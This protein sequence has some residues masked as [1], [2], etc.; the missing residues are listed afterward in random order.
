MFRFDSKIW[1]VKSFITSPTKVQ[2]PDCRTKVFWLMQRN[3][4]KEMA[5]SGYKPGSLDE[6][7]RIALP[8]I[9]SKFFSDKHAKILDIGAG[10]GHSLVPLKI[11]G[12]TNLW[13]LDI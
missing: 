4:L 3:Y 12:W 1:G 8:L 11:A 13:A 7:H 6:F 9:G 5:D 2:N 10:S